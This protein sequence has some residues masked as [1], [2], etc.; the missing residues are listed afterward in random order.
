MHTAICKAA[1]ERR[2]RASEAWLA[3]ILR[4]VGEGIIACNSDGEVAR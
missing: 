4:S 3:T 2:L 1:M